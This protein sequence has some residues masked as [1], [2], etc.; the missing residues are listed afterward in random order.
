M[1]Y[2]ELFYTFFK[3]GLFSFGGGYAMIPLLQKEIEMHNWLSLQEFADIVAISQMTP[4]PL[5][6]NT[7]TYI[8]NNIAGFWGSALATFGVSLPSLI[9]IIIVARF[10]IHFQDNPWV[11]GAMKGIRP[12]TA[13]LIASAVVFFAEMSIF[14]KEL[15]FRHLTSLF[16]GGFSQL[17]DG[18]GFNHGAV[19]IFLLIIIGIKK[20][21]LSAILAV[22][23]SAI[24]GIFLT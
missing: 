1:I 21:K 7:A 24:L 12:A 15:P 4:G 14:T 20:F 5:A 9:L 2:F 19:L 10:L 13:G 6:V 17:W 8:G 11:S 18:F 3:I 16:N 22:I 23:I